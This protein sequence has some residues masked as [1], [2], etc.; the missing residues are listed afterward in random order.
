MK[1]I[2]AE[3]RL[4]Q[5]QLLELRCCPL[6][7]DGTFRLSSLGGEEVAVQSLLLGEFPHGKTFF[8]FEKIVINLTGLQGTNEYNRLL[9]P[10]PG[11]TLT[12][13]Q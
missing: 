6:P 12:E 2:E 8:R 1:K 9:F 4:G 5:H 7:P 13:C 10:Y 3:L 11:F